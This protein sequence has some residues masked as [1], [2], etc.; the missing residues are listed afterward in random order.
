MPCLGSMS[1]WPDIADQKWKTSFPRARLAGK[2]GTISEPSL[3]STYVA[4][5]N[6]R[7]YGC[8]EADFNCRL[9]PKISV[10]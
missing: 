3:S 4:G 5:P 8:A 9:A 7:S 2:L 10:T 6:R 1:A